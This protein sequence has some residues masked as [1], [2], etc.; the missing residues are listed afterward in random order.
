MQPYL[1]DEKASSKSLSRS[2]KKITTVPTS[3]AAAMVND[4][5]C[6]TSERKKNP[7]NN[8]STSRSRK[9]LNSSIGNEESRDVEVYNMPEFSTDEINN[10][11]D[12]IGTQKMDEYLETL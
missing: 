2:Y 1:Q 10:M 4:A 9:S 3:V 8:Y 7:D 11:A 12:I 6:R 5:R